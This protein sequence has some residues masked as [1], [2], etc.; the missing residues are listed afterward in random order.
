VKDDAPGGSMA[1]RSGS[2]RWWENYLVRYFLPSLAGMLIVLW[3]VRF[4]G[5]SLYVP[6]LLPNEWK[7]F[8]TAHLILWLL[9]GSLYC[10]IASYPALVFHATRILDFRNVNGQFTGLPYFLLNP[11]GLS[12]TFAA[13][14][15]VCAY[16]DSRWFAFVSVALFA[17][18]Q[19]L[20][21]WIV[22][23][24]QGPFGLAKDFGARF[25]AS[26]A[27]AYLRKLSKRRA[28]FVTETKTSGG[29]GL[30]ELATSA[31]AK[32]LVDSYRHLR[33][34]G[35]TAFIVLLELALCPV[36]YLVLE[37]QDGAFNK[38]LFL[39]V[40]ALWVLPSVLIHG[41]AQHLE[42]RFSRFKYSMEDTGE[43]ET[44][45]VSPPK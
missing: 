32:D 6:Q 38:I 24:T 15:A 44:Y 28:D 25:P 34:H 11:Y 42:R 37:H 18:T 9:L 5:A 20:R 16:Y 8:G 27:Y 39:T 26:I 12:A 41:L 7:D 17:L 40:L 2:T 31:D 35:N 45:E 21:I 10:Y 43:N 14:A 19:I 29:D 22:Y 4:S 1:E 30:E 3:L 13:I 23:A 33:E 36:L